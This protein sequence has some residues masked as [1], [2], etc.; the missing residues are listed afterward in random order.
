MFRVRARDVH[1]ISRDAFALVQRARHL[2]VVLAGIAKDVGDDDDVFLAAQ[3]GEFLV[4]ECAHADVLQADR[5]QHSGGSLKDARRRIARHGLARKP[6]HHEAA[7]LF[8]AH[9]VFELDAV[10][11]GPAGGDH[12]VLESNAAEFDGKVG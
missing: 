5:I 7:Q 12:G 2:L 1:L 9:D 4:Q 8:Q 10:A 3:L 6:F 11:K